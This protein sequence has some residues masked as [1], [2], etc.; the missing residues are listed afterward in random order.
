[1]SSFGV[2]LS[3]DWLGS[4]ACTTETSLHVHTEFL[5]FLTHPER[6]GQTRPNS[7]FASAGWLDLFSQL[8]HI[9]LQQLPRALRHRDQQLRTG[10]AAPAAAHRP[11]AH[12]HG[13]QRAYAGLVVIRQP[14]FLTGLAQCCVE[15]VGVNVE[16]HGWRQGSGK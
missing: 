10:L 5:S 13:E 7:Y 6:Q 1:M 14:Q 8:P 3:S 12:R 11:L 4:A 9:N 16:R 15:G 2:R